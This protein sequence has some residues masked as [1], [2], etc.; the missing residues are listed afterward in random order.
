M[1]LLHGVE[2]REGL[3]QSQDL[4]DLHLLRIIEKAVEPGGQGL[5]RRADLS[6]EAI[7][8]EKQG[9][10]LRGVRGCPLEGY[11]ERLLGR[12][13]LGQDGLNGLLASIQ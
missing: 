2:R 3:C 8:G 1:E 9:A 13:E 6:L 4:G 11:I 5:F 7:D 12:I 10:E